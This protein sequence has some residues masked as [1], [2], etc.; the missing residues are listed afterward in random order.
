MEPREKPRLRP[1]S[2]LGPRSI[3]D[4]LEESLR[5]F[6]GLSSTDPTSQNEWNLT[7]LRE[8]PD[9]PHRS[10]ISC[11]AVADV[12]GPMRSELMIL[13]GLMIIR[14]R[15]KEKPFLHDDT[16]PVSALQ[17]LIHKIS[18]TTFDLLH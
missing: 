9:H 17:L 15:R 13:T 1:N 16:F 6:E 2:L 18:H 12:I 5:E 4:S 7:D 3:E 11:H 14:M 10:C 8:I